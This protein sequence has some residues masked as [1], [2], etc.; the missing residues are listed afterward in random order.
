MALITQNIYG[1]ITI[2]DEFVAAIA[3]RAAAECYGVVGLA[4]KKLTDSFAELFNRP[5]AGKGIRVI[6]DNNCVYIDVFVVL[7]EGINIDAVKESLR[8]SVSYS[9]ENFTGMRVKGVTV[10]VVGVSVS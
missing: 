9:V 3:Q 5:S 8:S 6:T 1:R 7:K 4:A 10:N 2:S